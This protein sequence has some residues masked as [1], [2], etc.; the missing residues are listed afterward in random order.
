MKINRIL[1]VHDEGISNHGSSMQLIGIKSKTISS[2]SSLGRNQIAYHQ[3]I[4]LAPVRNIK[5]EAIKKYAVI[6]YFLT[7]SVIFVQRNSQEQVL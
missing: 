2:T 6:Y 3:V 5:K 1:N 7:K 4:H